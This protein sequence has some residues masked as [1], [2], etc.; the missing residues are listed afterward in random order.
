MTVPPDLCSLL[1]SPLFLNSLLL[2]LLFFLQELQRGPSDGESDGAPLRLRP[3]LHHRE[4]HLRL[5]PPEAGGA[6]IPAQPEGGGGH[7]EVQ[8]PG[9]VPGESV[10]AGA[11]YGMSRSSSVVFVTAVICTSSSL[12]CRCTQT[13]L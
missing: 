2:P 5:L 9:Q 10:A 3:D 7:A 1:S 6:E 8:A 4:D 12:S 11:N 13:I